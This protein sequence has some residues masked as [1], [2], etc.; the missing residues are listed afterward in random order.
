MYKI[1][2]PSAAGSLCLLAFAA[3]AHGAVI[4]NPV[5]TNSPSEF[6]ASFAAAN[7]FDGTPAFNVATGQGNQW[8]GSGVG[9]HTI[10]FNFGAVTTFGW[11]AYAQRSGSNPAL[12]KVTSINF[13]FSNAPDFSNPTT[14]TVNITN[15]ASANYWAYNFASSFSGQYVRA[16]FNGSGGNPGGSELRFYNPARPALANPVILGSPSQ[17]D[18]SFAA[19][20]LFDGSGELGLSA[21][22]NQWAG[23]GGGP[24]TIDFDFGTA[25]SVNALGYAQRQGGNPAVDKVTSVSLYFSDINGVFGGVPNTVLSITNVTDNLLTEYSLGSAQSG[26]YLRAVFTG[27]GGNPGGSELRFYGA[28][29]PEPAAGLLTFLASGALLARRR[30]K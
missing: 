15:V 13:T 5:I 8:A 7:L 12:D 26:R 16:V 1:S 17:F 28:V 10:D 2:L 19:A 23:L 6:N 4:T 22:N 9:P 24:H 30:R 11:L 14:T 29:V 18:A 3:Q 20:N 27:N 25:V 21:N